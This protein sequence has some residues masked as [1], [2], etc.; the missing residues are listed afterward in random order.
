MYLCVGSNGMYIY[1]DI[2]PRVG[3]NDIHTDMVRAAFSHEEILK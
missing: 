3:Y 2:V 1:R